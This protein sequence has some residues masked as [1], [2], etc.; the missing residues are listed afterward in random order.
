MPDAA[1]KQRKEKSTPRQLG[2]TVEKRRRA[3]G[4][5]NAMSSV[6]SESRTGQ[7]FSKKYVPDD[8]GLL[9][10]SIGIL[11]QAKTHRTGEID[12]R[13]AQE[14]MLHKSGGQKL[15]RGK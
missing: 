12:A 7:C 1:G 11:P 13:T 2:Q 5:T 14:V 9:C 10:L 3:P 4:R 6:F 8:D 15:A